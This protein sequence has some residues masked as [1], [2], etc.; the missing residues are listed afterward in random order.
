MTSA[1]VPPKRRK[2]IRIIEDSDEDEN[3]CCTA[4]T[5]VSLKKCKQDRSNIH[6]KTGIQARLTAL[7]FQ[8]ETAVN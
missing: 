6:N 7:R 3:A 8:V 1:H 4:A 2:R 5:A